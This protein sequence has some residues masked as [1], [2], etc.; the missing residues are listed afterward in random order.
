MQEGIPGCGGTYTASRGDISSPINPSDGKYKHNLACDYLIRMPKD[1][2]VRLTFQ[3]FKLESSPNCKF[4]KVEIFDGDI[5]DDDKLIGRYCGENAPPVITS[6]TNVVTVRFTSDWSTNDDGF[7]IQYQLVCGGKFT[8]ENGIISSPNYPNN[9]SSD[10]HCEYDIIAPE[11][12]VI[13]LN[14]LDFD[15]EKHSV[16][17]FDHLEIFDFPTSDNR[18]SLGRFCGQTKPGIITSTYNHLHIHFQSD[19]SIGGRGF[20]ANYSFVDVSCG[21]IITDANKVIRSPMST[22]QNGLYLPNMKCRWVIVAPKGFV[23]QMNFIT[24]EL[25]LGKQS[26]FTSHISYHSLFNVNSI[27]FECKSNSDYLTI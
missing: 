12:F 27:E 18:T 1:S 7:Q 22:D 15:F 4:D 25:E 13:V 8:A 9:Y 26:H 11:G 24:F 23:I 16:C 5:N 2:R 17:E 21:G 19:A 10:R 14:V 3:K 20:M 6:L